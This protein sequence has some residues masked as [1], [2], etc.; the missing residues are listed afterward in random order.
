MITREDKFA[1][2]LLVMKVPITVD[3]F[4]KGTIVNTAS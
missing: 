4:E 3:F 2:S 1:D